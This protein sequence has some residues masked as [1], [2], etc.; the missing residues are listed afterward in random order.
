MPSSILYSI[1]KT[2]KLSVVSLHSY[3]FKF[4]GKDFKAS[5]KAIDGV[6]EAIEYNDPN[7]FILGVHF[8]PELDDNN[9]IFERLIAEG[10]KR[11]NN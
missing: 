4:V 9:L 1:Y 3:D 8:H 11:K 10:E 2:N 6:N 5:A 7:Y